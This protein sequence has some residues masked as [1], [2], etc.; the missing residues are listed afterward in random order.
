MWVIA[1]GRVGPV[2]VFFLACHLHRNR[3]AVNHSPS[4][5]LQRCF[6]FKD[7]DVGDKSKAFFHLQ[8]RIGTGARVQFFPEALQGDAMG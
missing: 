4:Q 3:A 2:G 1:A 5:F 6:G 7:I 8:L